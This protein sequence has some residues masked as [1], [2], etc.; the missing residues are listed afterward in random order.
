MRLIEIVKA[1]FGERWRQRNPEIP[2]ED[3]AEDIRFT[4]RGFAFVAGLVL[5][6]AIGIMLIEGCV[7][8]ASPIAGLGMRECVK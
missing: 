3:D 6:T 2:D 5:L 4:M 8:D 1:H 7:P